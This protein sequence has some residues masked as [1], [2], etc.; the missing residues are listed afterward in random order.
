MRFWRIPRWKSG[1]GTCQRDCDA[2]S[3]AMKAS[4]KS[5]ADLAR[6]LRILVRERLV[7]GDSDDEVID[8]VVDRYG[9]YVLL[10]PRFDGSTWILWAAG[11]A[12]LL[13]AAGIG[14]A[15]I[16]GRET[17]KPVQEAGLTPEEKARLDKILKE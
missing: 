12:M 13:L 2:L 11:P 16:R 14:F 5:N 15:Y 4:M 1:R 17:A 6:D 7:E 3:A 9:E 8:F 10:K